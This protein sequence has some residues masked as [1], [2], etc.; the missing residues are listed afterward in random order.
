MSKR[1]SLASAAVAWLGLA[2]CAS[3]QPKPSPSPSPGF[4]SVPAAQPVN[5]PA[6][7]AISC[8]AAAR[9]WI[10]T[11]LRDLTPKQQ[12]HLTAVMINEFGDPCFF[13]GDRDFAVAGD[14]IYAATYLSSNTAA[15]SVR[16]EN[17]AAESAFSLQAGGDLFVPQAKEAAGPAWA[18]APRRVCHGGGTVDVV[19]S[20]FTA[21]PDGTLNE[22]VV[23]KTALNQYARY[24]ATLQL[25]AVYTTRREVTFG[26]RKDGDVNR[27]FTQ[28]PLDRGPEYVGILNVYAV[29]RYLGRSPWGGLY[30]G[31]DI[32]HD[33]AL[34]DRIGLVFGAG[35][36]KPSRRF[37]AGGSFE[38][39]PG[40]SA[41][42]VYEWVQVKQLAG[43]SEGNPFGEAADKIPTRDEWQKGWVI[44]ASFDLLYATKLFGK[45]P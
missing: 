7:P 22:P 37:M 44:G 27:I 20:T 6:A 2:V 35:L 29:P 17:C 42:G 15:A 33:H 30:K 8:T 12:T 13:H 23:K 34:P 25:G 10:Q 43:L 4:D 41:I 28:T 14:A 31:R 32:V 3:A 9:R 5:P 40:V 38:L 24:R 19:S 21:K 45:K 39:F 36:S 11:V 18:A 16:L 26:L 1:Q